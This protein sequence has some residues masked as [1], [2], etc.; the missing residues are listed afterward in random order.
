MFDY[1]DLVHPFQNDPGSS[2]ST[3]VMEDLLAGPS[4]IDGRRL[5]DLLNYFTE[6]APHIKFS[7]TDAQDNHSTLKASDWSA[8]FADSLPF[9]LAAAAGNNGDKVNDK[10]Q[11]YLNLFSQ[12][13]SPNRLQLLIWYLYYST[14]YKLN[15]LYL[16]VSNS[17]LPI[18]AVLEQQIKNQLKLPVTHFM[19]AAYTANSLFGIRLIDFTPLFGNPIW[20]IGEADVKSG[21]PAILVLVGEEA[22]LAALRD[23]VNGT[24]TAVLAAMKVV[25]AS[26][27]T[28]LGQSLTAV[29]DELKQMHTPHLALLF[30]FLNIFRQLQ[31]DLNSYTKK[32]LDF[33]Y[34]QVLQ[35]QPKAAQPDELHIVFQLQKQLQQYLLK[36]GLQVKADKDKNGV[37]MDFALNDDIVVNKTQV[38]DLRTLF[39]NNEPAGEKTYVE[40]AYMAPEVDTTQIFPTLGSQLPPSARIGFV[41]ASPV[42]LLHEGARTIDMVLTC[43]IVRQLSASDQPEYPDFLDAASLF[44]AVKSLIGGTYIYISRELIQQAKDKGLDGTKAD[45]I[46]DTYVKDTDDIVITRDAWNSFLQAQAFTSEAQNFLL[47]LFKPFKP[48]S[49]LFSGEKDWI[50]PSENLSLSIDGASSSFTIHISAGITADQPAITNYNKDNL[51]EDLGSSLPLV[52]IELNDAI[53]IALDKQT[54]TTLAPEDP[55]LFRKKDDLSNVYVSLYHFFRDTVVQDSNITVTVC[56]L[57]EFVVQ[58]DE[59]VQDVNGPIY[60][61]G[62]RPAIIDFDD[63]MSYDVKERPDDTKKNLIGPN[64]YVGSAEIFSKT[65]KKICLKVNWKDKPNSFNEHYKGYLKRLNYHDCSGAPMDVYGLNDCEFEVN[66]SLLDQGQW[67]QEKDSSGKGAKTKPNT[68]Y[69]RKLFVSEPCQTGCADTGSYKYSF[70]IES[71]D[72][73]VQA[74]YEEPII[75][76]SKYDAGTRKGFLRLTLE[77]QDFM[78]KDYAFVLS[79]QMMALGRFPDAILEGAVYAGSGNTVIVYQDIGNT[80]VQLKDAIEKAA[81][82]AANLKSNADQLRGD[83]IAAQGGEEP[84][85]SI[86]DADRDAMKPE[87]DANQRLSGSVAEDAAASADKLKSLEELYP[88]FQQGKPVQ[89]LSVIIPNEPWTPIISNISLDYTATAD[90]TAITLVHLYPYQSTYKQQQLTL[91]PAL[92][93]TFY[94][95]GTLFIGLTDLVPGSIVNILFQLAE[96]TSDAESDIQ[97][98]YWQYLQNN[99]W[100]PLRKG[101]E[102]VN[103]DTDNLTASGIIKFAFP[104]TMTAD[105]TVMP[106]GLYWIKA[107]VPQN[108]RAVCQTIGIYTQAVKTTFVIDPANDTTRLS[109][110]LPQGSVSKLRVADA[111]IKQVTQPAASFDGREPEANKHYYLRVSELLRHKGRAI[112]KFDYERLVLEAFPEVFKTKCI[113]HSFRLD[114]NKYDNDFP[115]APGYVLVAVIPDLTKLLAGESFEPML[116]TGSIEKIQDFLSL[117]SSP[118]VRIKA[119]NPRY[120]KINFYLSVILRQ[121]YDKPFYTD[122]LAQDLREFLAPWAV[123]MYDKLRFG[124]CVNKSDVVEFLETREYVDYITKL[125]MLGEFDAGPPSESTTEVCPRTPRSILL[126]GEIQVFSEDNE[127]QAWKNAPPC[128]GNTPFVSY[129]KQI[130]TIPV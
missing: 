52:K 72:F 119:V 115:I 79:R 4:K 33:F 55:C 46:S 53:K 122:K 92:L 94:D 19:K 38:T 34:Q 75:S 124:Q 95:E 41:L 10:F 9:I 70:Y 5:A 1:K 77:N 78:H 89:D 98:V 127:P 103:D 120:E 118:F 39:L 7:Y 93:P 107:S 91:A 104:D 47:Q 21:D 129:P 85:R 28:C 56:E 48:F 61:F 99:Q 69:N 101:F 24:F 20:E 62:T 8:F 106:K 12:S 126:A 35:L 71:T 76:L 58:N 32:H 109:D 65:W 130:K 31:G 125:Q 57:K 37:E 128:N 54:L 26:S 105:N 113:N 25:S 49:V 108:S 67:H 81:T 60:P 88:V 22:R 64:F 15:Q 83:Y 111:N 86:S 51:N 36:K 112:Q 42:L 73:D 100:L 40:G 17:G 123:G 117:C 16:P 66:L 84:T 23:S 102:L 43:S 3:R 59:S 110:P 68:D 45:S 97:P 116:P 121:G 27:G 80:I 2:Q 13:P 90:K 30:T 18:T 6:L 63:V 96:A 82:D 14:V 50:D 11:F 29:K 114:A 44:P 87:V 74:N